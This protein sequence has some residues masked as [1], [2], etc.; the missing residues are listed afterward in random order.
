MAAVA[1]VILYA[2]D[3]K[4]ASA[5]YAA[6]LG[7]T[8]RLDVPRMTEFELAG[9]AVLGLMPEAGIHLLRGDALPLAGAAPSLSAELYLLVADPRC[10]A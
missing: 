7:I 9:G 10:D 6:V 8:P 5:F 2:R 1:H 3:Q 4:R